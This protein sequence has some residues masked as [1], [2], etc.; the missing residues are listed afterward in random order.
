MTMNTATHIRLTGP[1]PDYGTRTR[2]PG[3]SQPAIWNVFAAD[4]AGHPVSR[5]YAVP[6][7]FN[8]ALLL[9]RR[10]ARDRGRMRF[11]IATSGEPAPAFPLS[12]FN[13]HMRKAAPK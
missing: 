2:P 1:T 8:L 9:M 11:K 13:Q 7:Y 10:I 6:D 5:V 3:G 12:L 4:R